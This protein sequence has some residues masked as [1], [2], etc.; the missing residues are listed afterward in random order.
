M[1]FQ[2]VAD[3]RREDGSVP[4]VQLAPEWEERFATYQIESD[5]GGIDIALPP[6]QFNRLS[7]AVSEKMNA[8]S[9]QGVVP[10]LVTSVRRRRFLRT[11]MQSTGL[12]NPV[13]S[14]EEL[15]TDVRPALIGVV[16]A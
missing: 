8:I 14:F 15:G 1:G 4:L 16:A 12:V 9:E 11:V 5:R 3:M 10:A 6:D 13:L 2:L 7:A